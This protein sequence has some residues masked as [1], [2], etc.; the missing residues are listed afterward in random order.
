MIYILER[1][2]KLPLGHSEFQHDITFSNNIFTKSSAVLD[3]FFEEFDKTWH[4]EIKEKKLSF[5]PPERNN[6][7][8]DGTVEYLYNDEYFRC[9][10]FIKDHKETHVL[11]AGCS[12][13]EGVGGNLD[14]CWAY[15]TYKE[16][17]KTNKMSGYFNIAK[18]GFGWQKVITNTLVY[19][20]KYGAPDYLFIL[21][22]DNN[23]SFNWR[24]SDSCWEYMQ[25]WDLD[26]VN[27][28]RNLIDLMVSWRLFLEFCKL[29]NIKIIWTTW[30]NDT[31]YYEKANLEN[32]L[33][34]DYG[35]YK[36]Y[37]ELFSNGEM[38]RSDLERKRDG[39]SGFAR[40]KIWSSG[41][42]EE[43]K[44]RN[45]ENLSVY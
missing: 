18:S 13:T 29:Q 27:H 21:L 34:I 11:F 2:I 22:P 35:L 10:N 17:E 36:K 24:E 41:F 1:I 28:Q 40:H 16:L 32:F 4:Q 3:V 38:K 5:V 31:E 39:H 42:L 44:R 20:K 15:M 7:E 25:K 43:I 6:C 33:K 45:Y 8:D 30:S 14:A 9:D 19:I 37:I 26:V 23:R 12:E